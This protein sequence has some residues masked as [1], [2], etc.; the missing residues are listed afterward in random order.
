M[1]AASSGGSNSEGS[2]CVQRLA[3]Q[4]AW[5]G[6]AK[7]VVGGAGHGI[8]RTTVLPG[9]SVERGSIAAW[10]AGQPVLLATWLE[11]ISVKQRSTLDL[12]S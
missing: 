9:A 6:E 5:R 1:D 8:Q 11:L 7:G 2:C 10:R 4:G 12:V 3:R